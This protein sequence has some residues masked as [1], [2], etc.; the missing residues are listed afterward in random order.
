MN[1]E[2][3]RDQPVFPQLFDSKASIIGGERF[4]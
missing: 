2:I 4:M 3:R 1:L